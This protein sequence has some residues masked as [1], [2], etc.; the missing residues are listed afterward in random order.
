[1]KSHIFAGNIRPAVTSVQLP[2]SCLKAYVEICYALENTNI[3]LTH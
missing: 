2:T 1:M 3:S